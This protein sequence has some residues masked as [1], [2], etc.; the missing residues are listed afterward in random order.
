MI[1][2]LRQTV[3]IL[4]VLSVITGIFYPLLVTGLAQLLFHHQANGSVVKD[5]DG[6]PVGSELIGQPF[7]SDR[8]FWSRPSAT[9]DGG[10]KDQPYNAANSTGSNLGPT[11]PD[12]ADKVT[13]RAARLRSANPA[14]QPGEAVPVD[15]VTA[16]ASGLD[17]DISLAAAEYQIPRVAKAR[18]MD[19]AKLRELVARIAQQ[20]QFGILGEPRMNVLKLN[21]ALDDL[22]DLDAKAR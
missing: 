7:S 12:L 6:R 3:G 18:T 16:S 19:Q 9:N 17:P 4:L 13:A 11:N 21:L 8:Y 1:R 2:A 5:K 20:R 22:D 14:S 15:M 10:G